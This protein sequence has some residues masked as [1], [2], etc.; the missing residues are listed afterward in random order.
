MIHGYW[1]DALD[2]RFV[3]YRYMLLWTVTPLFVGLWLY[4]RLEKRIISL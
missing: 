4:Q 3:D 2:D 1:I